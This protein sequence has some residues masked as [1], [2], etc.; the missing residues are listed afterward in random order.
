M[1][2]LNVWIL[3]CC[4]I[5]FKLKVKSLEYSN[6]LLLYRHI[7]GTTTHLSQLSRNIDICTLL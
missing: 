6:D 7:F 4:V 1:S 2:A 5:Q 3:N